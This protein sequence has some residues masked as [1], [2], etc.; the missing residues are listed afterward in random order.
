MVA[1]GTQY[2]QYWWMGTFPGLAIFTVVLAFNFLGDSLRDFSIPAGPTEGG[3]EPSDAPRRRGLERPLPPRRVT[4][5][6]GRRCVDYEVGQGAVFGDRRRERQRQDHVGARAH[7]R[8][9]PPA[10]RSTGSALFAADDLL[11]MRPSKLRTGLRTRYRPGLPGPHDLAAPDAH[12]RAAA[13]R[14]HASSL[15]VSRR[16]GPSS[17]RPTSSSRCGSRIQRGP[18]RYPHEFSGGMRQRIAIADRPDVRAA[19]P[20]RRRANDRARCHRAGRDPP[21]DRPPATG[22]LPSVILITHDLGVMSALADDLPSSTADRSSRR[23]RRR[24]Y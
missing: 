23:G 15:G 16:R 11:S 21:P 3:A 8:C 12:G 1:V 19:T 20:D 13:D 6:D 4:D 9:F 7:G 22:P 18:G 24:S 14:A 10:R 2:F 5:P 17:A